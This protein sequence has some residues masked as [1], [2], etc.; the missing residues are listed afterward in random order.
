MRE[1]IQGV[2][3]ASS[4]LNDEFWLILDRSFIPTDGL[5]CYYPEEIPL[6]KDK[7]AQELR[8]I[9]EVKL[10]FSGARVTR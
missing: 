1:N 10:A 2:R 5:A 8:Q 9:H 6:L 7:T 3:I 4:I